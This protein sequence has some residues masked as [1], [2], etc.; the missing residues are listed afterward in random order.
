MKRRGFTLIEIMLVIMILGTLA[1]IIIPRVVHRTYD[2]KR[3]KAVA[4]IA[5]LKSMVEQVRM[6][7]KR[8]PTEQ[9]GLSIL[10]TA[11]GE[12]KGWQGPY[13][14]TVPL[15]PWGNQYVYASGSGGTTDSFQITCLGADGAQGGDGE[16]ADITDAQ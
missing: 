3:A 1:T 11:P 9:E 6:D 8:Y 4:D 13:M 5:L 7:I 10:Q 14:Q 15:D 16:A 2:G 12:T